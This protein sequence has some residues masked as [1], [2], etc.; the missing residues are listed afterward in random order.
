MTGKLLSRFAAFSM[1]CFFVLWSC[2]KT[3]TTPDAPNLP[4]PPTDT[5]A[6]SLSCEPNSGGPDTIITI[7]ISI[8]E[9]SR[10]MRAFGLVMS[11]DSQM[12]KFQSVGKGGLTGSWAMVD[13]NETGTGSLTIGGYVG[14]GSSVPAQSNGSIVEVKMKVTGGTY[15]DGQQSQISMQSYTDDL[16]GFSPEP[17]STTFTLRK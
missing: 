16:A 14:S 10:E 11:F 8:R 2:G 17:A 3:P 9:N 6:V 7:T 13:G 1:A 5:S 12:F 15:P 4:P